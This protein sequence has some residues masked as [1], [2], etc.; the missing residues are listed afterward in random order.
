MS[1]KIHSMPTGYGNHDM[2]DIPVAQDSTPLV[3]VSPDH[4]MPKGNNESSD[5]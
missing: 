2:E 3:L 1:Q 4:T 5:E